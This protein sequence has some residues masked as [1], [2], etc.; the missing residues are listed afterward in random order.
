MPSFL[1]PFKPPDPQSVLGGTLGGHVLNQSHLSQYILCT[2]QNGGTG[3][4]TGLDLCTLN[5]FVFYV[6]VAGRGL[7]GWIQSSS[8]W[9]SVLRRGI[10]PK[11]PAV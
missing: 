9:V 8:L 6:C 1:G 7:Q 5:C 2:R 3:V 11:V 10:V 4:L